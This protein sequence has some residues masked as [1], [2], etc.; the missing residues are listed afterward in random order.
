M[1]K[2]IQKLLKRDGKL[3]DIKIAIEQEEVRDVF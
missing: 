1:T 2:V 3:K